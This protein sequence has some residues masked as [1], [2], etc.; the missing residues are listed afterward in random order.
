MACAVP[1]QRNEPIGWIPA[2]GALTVTEVL[3]KH[4]MISLL[5]DG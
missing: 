1:S 2:G 3:G 5:S 4:G